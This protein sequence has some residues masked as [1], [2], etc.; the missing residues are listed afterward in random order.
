ML[1]SGRNPVA[2]RCKERPRWYQLTDLVVVLL[3]TWARFEVEKGVV[4]SLCGLF[5]V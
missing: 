2:E 5:Q 4:N 3:G 1:L